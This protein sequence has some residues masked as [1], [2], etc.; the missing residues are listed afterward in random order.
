MSLFTMF[1]LFYFIAE[2]SST[3]SILRQVLSTA[4]SI[5]RH[6]HYCHSSLSIP[7][8]PLWSIPHSLFRPSLLLSCYKMC[9]SIEWEDWQNRGTVGWWEEIDWVGV[10]EDNMIYERIYQEGERDRNT[11]GE[12]KEKEETVVSH[13]CN[14]RK[15]HDIMGESKRRLSRAILHCRIDPTCTYRL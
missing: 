1:H 12:G 10:K 3:Q 8:L 13:S 2:Y 15:G 11:G 9:D 5:V 7:I 6:L 4:T 14:R